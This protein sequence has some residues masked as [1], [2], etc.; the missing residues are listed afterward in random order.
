MAR[1]I[2]VMAGGTGGHLFPALAVA[3]SL[4]TRGWEVR[5]LGATGRMETYLIPQHGIEVEAINISGLV[6][7]GA[8]AWLSAP[9]RISVALSQAIKV[10]KRFRPDVVLGMGGYVS[11]PGGVAAW[12]AGI[13]LVVHEQ[14]SVLGLTNRCLRVLAKRLLAAFPLPFREAELVG[15]P[16]RDS[17]QRLPGPE[18]RWRNRHGPLR[19]LVIGG[20][21]GCRTLNRVF[22]GVVARMGG[23]IDV[24]HQT[25]KGDRQEVEKSCAELSVGC[26]RVDEFITEMAHAYS[27]ADL[28]VGR[29]G[30]ATVSELAV[31]GLSAILIPFQ[32]RDR[33]QYLNAQYLERVG[34]ATIIEQS[35]LTEESLVAELLRYDRADLLR[36]AESA[37]TLVVGDATQRITEIIDQLAQHKI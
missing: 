33:H 22:P 8:R 24:W 17:L 1:R 36:R 32:H 10:I 18:L 37:R 19:I 23:K 28:V 20:S 35:D 12:L 31:V 21:Q 2:L 27:W 13:P 16:V 15:N 6:G 34:A 4:I 7:H 9:W 25:G 14:N 26:Y 29:S 5:W 3:Q 11:G 30:A